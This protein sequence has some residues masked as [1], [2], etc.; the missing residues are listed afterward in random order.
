MRNTRD[1]K[2]LFGFG[3]MLSFAVAAMAGEPWPNFRC[4][5]QHSGRTTRVSRVR[6]TVNWSVP[7]SGSIA[8]SPVMDADGNLYVA[9]ATGRVSAFDR[10]G[11]RL[12][13]FSTLGGIF[14]SP[15]LGPDSTIYVGDLTGVL[16]ALSPKGSVRWLYRIDNGGKD[17]RIVQ[18]PA[19]GPNGTIYASSWD[20]HVHAVT[21]EGKRHWTF[22]SGRLLSAS[23]A[24][25]SS[26]TIY[27][28]GLYEDTDLGVWALN[29]QGTQRWLFHRN[30]GSWPYPNETHVKSSVCVDEVRGRIL[31]GA[32]CP[33]G[34]F[35]C[36]LNLRDGSPVRWVPFGSAIYSA[37]AVDSKGI[38]YF[39]ALD[40]CLYAYDL[41]SGK[42]KWRF[43][44]GGDFIFGSP[45]A[46]GNRNVYVGS[47]DG[48][49]YKVTADGKEAWRFPANAE[50]RS[51]PVIDENGL[52]YFGSM[53]GRL[54]SLGGTAS[55]PQSPPRR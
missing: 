38:V 53:N 50:I 16:Y 48:C 37:P 40:G 32:N 30:M 9:T 23:P 4:D 27:V 35:L 34:G 6:P 55:A 20:G 31:V 43:K 42:S 5:M 54:F 52:L 45:L 26:G 15:T 14:G 3:I 24:I 10:A 22:N 47:S 41:E 44:T 25:D 46:E 36:C 13:D 39:G 49:L 51:T 19:V 2:F 1:R 33:L 8:G 18:A 12:W 28:V 17:A 11:K 7:T 29:P 21:P